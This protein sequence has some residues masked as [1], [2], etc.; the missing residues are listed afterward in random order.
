[1]KYLKWIGVI[2]A[3]LLIIDFISYLFSDKPEP[4]P[5][6]AEL[7]ITQSEVYG[8]NSDVLSIKTGNY[9][10][11][12]KDGSILLKIRLKLNKTIDEKYEISGPYIHL[13]NEMG[14]DVMGSGFGSTLSLG[15][16]EASKL[17]SFLH[18][19]PGTEQDFIF[20]DTYPNNA[21]KTM[22]ETRGITLENLKLELP[23]DESIKSQSEKIKDGIETLGDIFDEASKEVVD[24]KD[25]QKAVDDMEKVLNLSEK[26][27]EFTKSTVELSKEIEKQQK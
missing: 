9:F 6:K 26:A 25:V 5:E 1:M 2:A 24:D 13:K 3:A 22:T 19:D 16:S 17:L 21:H 4:V 15:S 23:K 27:L 11:Y 12:Y 10:L 8:K 20:T 7:N 18:S 14:T